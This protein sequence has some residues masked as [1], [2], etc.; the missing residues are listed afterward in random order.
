MDFW[1]NR[2]QIF[3]RKSTNFFLTFGPISKKRKFLR[4]WLIFSASP[5]SK[6]AKSR[7]GLWPRPGPAEGGNFQNFTFRGKNAFFGPNYTPDTQILTFGPNLKNR[8]FSILADFFTF[9]SIFGPP[10]PRKSLTCERLGGPAGARRRPG[11]LAKP[12]GPHPGQAR[13]YKNSVFPGRGHGD[14]KISPTGGPRKS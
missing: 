14:G 13:A 9:F 10:R 2:S 7:R 12:Q 11:E 8:F 6:I 4:F 3:G 5:A 1:E